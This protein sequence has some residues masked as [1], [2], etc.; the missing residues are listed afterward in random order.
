MKAISKSK[1]LPFFKDP[2]CFLT[3]LLPLIFLTVSFLSPN[4]C[5]QPDDIE[6][7]RI[8]I[9]HELSNKCSLLYFTRL[10]RFKV[11]WHN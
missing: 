3:K 10:S 9:E 7:E 4:L 11:V 5:A 8:S 1:C 6:F 2:Q